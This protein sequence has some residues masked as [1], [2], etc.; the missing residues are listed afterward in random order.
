MREAEGRLSDFKAQ[1]LSNSLWA[2]A[3]LGH[4]DC[5]FKSRLLQA[6]RAQL[7]GFQPQDV[8]N[9]AFARATLRYQDPDFMR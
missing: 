5:S 2:L 3:K 8:S 7:Q 6:A 1:A 9:T 4:V